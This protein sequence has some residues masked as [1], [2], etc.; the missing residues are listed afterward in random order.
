MKMSVTATAA[1]TAVA[2]VFAVPSAIAAGT[3]P[4][5]KPVPAQTYQVMQRFVAFNPTDLKIRTGD[6]VVWTNKETDDTTHSVVQ[7]NGDE[8]DSPDIQPG[9]QFIWKFDFPGEWDIVCR[10]HPAMYLT[11]NV[12]GKAVPGAKLPAQQHHT[13]AAP[14]AAKP[15]QPGGSTIPGVTGLPIAADRRARR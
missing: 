1:V 11:V 10:F 2:T 7:G 14:P 12:V 15:T 3:G 5:D 13:T 8:I 9:Q 6:T 4:Q